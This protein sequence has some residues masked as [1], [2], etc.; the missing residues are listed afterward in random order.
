MK[1]PT[2]IAAALL[3][4]LFTASYAQQRHEHGGLT[5]GANGGFCRDHGSSLTICG[6]S[7]RSIFCSDIT[8][9]P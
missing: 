6:R 3:M 9:L 4:L 7:I 8:P 1:K 2:A 5:H